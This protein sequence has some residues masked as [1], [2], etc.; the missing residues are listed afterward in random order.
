MTLSDAAAVERGLFGGGW[1]NSDFSLSPLS[2]CTY[3]CGQMTT[4]PLSGQ[5]PWNRL[6]TAMVMDRLTMGCKSASSKYGCS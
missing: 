1:M 6:F 3:V 4:D 5:A 2:L